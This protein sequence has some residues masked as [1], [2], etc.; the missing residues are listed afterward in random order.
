MLDPREEP[1]TVAEMA[2]YL[3]RSE[4]TVR[5]YAKSKAIPAHKI[6]DGPKARWQFFLSEFHAARTAAASD[7]WALPSKRR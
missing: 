5:E 1:L 3:K 4:Y 7:P 6:G 2:A